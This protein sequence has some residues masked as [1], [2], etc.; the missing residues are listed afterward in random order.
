MTLLFKAVL[1]GVVEGLTEFL[2][3]SSTGHLIVAGKMIGFDDASFEIFI[4]LGAILAVVVVCWRDL[5]QRLRGMWHV[6]NDQRVV[7]RVLTAFAPA[8]IV[9]LALHHTIKQYLFN[10]LSVSLAMIVGGVA[11]IW[12]ERR[13]ATPTTHTL[14]TVRTRQALGIGGAQLLAM[15]PGF[16][17]AG[18]SILGGM[19]AGLDRTTATLFSFYLAI[20]TMFGATT[21]DLWKSRHDLHTDQFSAYAVGFLTSFLVAWFVIRWL[22]H[23]IAHHSF[24]VFGVYRVVVG[25]AILLMQIAK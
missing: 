22:L 12:I 18:A 10:P 7:V 17:R 5:G 9:G 21:L 8:V 16:S 4:Q 6:G 20:P 13:A 24:T 15:W 25:T 19:L 3:I 14:D 2:P 11:I 1:L 23:Y